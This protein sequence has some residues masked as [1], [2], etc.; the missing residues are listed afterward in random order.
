MKFPFKV[1]D[2]THNLNANIPSWNGSCGFEHQIKLDYTD[3]T[4]EVKFCVQQIKMH[5]GIG[6]HIDAPAHCIPG[7]KTIESLELENLIAPCVII[8]VSDKMTEKYSLSAEDVL[9]FEKQHGMIQANSF[10]IARTGWEK[11]WHTPNKYC[12]N[13]VFP[14]ISEKAALLLL[15]RNIV[16]VG[17]DTLSPD[18]PED[19]FPV[20]AAILGAG[21][22]IVENVA[23]SANLSPIGSYSLCLPIKTVGSTEAPI[24]L[25][26]LHV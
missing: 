20:H 22:Y 17:I 14:S 24:R 2:L 12:N 13:H 18:R 11:F 25:I 16:G 15:E 9:N 5:A 21:K 26:A 4:T 1:I 23:N 19:G 8:D 7:G 3:C 6:T 10:V